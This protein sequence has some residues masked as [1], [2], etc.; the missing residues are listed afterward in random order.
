MAG[1]QTRRAAAEEPEM[2]GPE[3]TWGATPEQKQAWADKNAAKNAAKKPAQE[4][5]SAADEAVES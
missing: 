4:P 5:E 3:S 1:R 2:E